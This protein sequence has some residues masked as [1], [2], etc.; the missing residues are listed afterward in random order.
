MLP[1]VLDNALRIESS[2]SISIFLSCEFL[3]TIS[4]FFYYNCGFSSATI[5]AN[6][7]YSNPEGVIAKLIIVT[8]TKIYGGYC[9]LG[10][11]VV[12]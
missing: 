3:R 11:V 7:C 2:I 9:G 12:M 5:C 6:I 4:S 1:S 8:L 10:I